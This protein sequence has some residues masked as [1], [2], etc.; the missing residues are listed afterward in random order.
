MCTFSI[1]LILIID[2]LGICFDFKYPFILF[3]ALENILK[4]VSVWEPPDS[5]DPDLNQQ[6]KTN[7]EIVDD[8]DCLFSLVK[9]EY[10]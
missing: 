8:V 4:N 1:F 7:L 2:Q 9:G 3:Q 6:D 10:L 5:P